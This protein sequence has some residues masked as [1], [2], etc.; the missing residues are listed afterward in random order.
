MAFFLSYYL[1][2]MFGILGAASWMDHL[3]GRKPE[4]NQAASF[5]SPRRTPEPKLLGNELSDQDYLMMYTSCSLLLP[6][7][8]VASKLLLDPHIQ[9]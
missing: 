4:A 6:F 2:Q 7:P 3:L 8:C 9:D 5:L 1:L